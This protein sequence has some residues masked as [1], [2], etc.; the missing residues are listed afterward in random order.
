MAIRYRWRGAAVF[1]AVFLLLWMGNPMEGGCEIWSDS[2]ISNLPDSSFI[3]IETREDGS[4]IRH[5]AYRDGDGQID[6]EQLV[7][8][9]GT[10]SEEKWLDDN[11]KRIAFRQLESHYQQMLSEWTKKGLQEPV[12]INSATL[13]RL[14]TLP[15]IGPVLAVRIHF[16]RQNH[17]KFQSIEGITKV[18]GIGQGTFNAIQHYI[19]AY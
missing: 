17:G 12:D 5:C 6:G 9:L 1:L 15:G 8:I 2:K 4:R 11:K 18:A 19:R 13:D 3:A 16:F 7:F 14:V 10:F